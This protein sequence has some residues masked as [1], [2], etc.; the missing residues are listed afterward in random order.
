VAADAVL[1][2]AEAAAGRCGGGGF[3]DGA[4][5]ALQAA[6]RH[7]VRTHQRGGKLAGVVGQVHIDVCGGD[8]SCRVWDPHIY[9]DIKHR[10]LTHW[11][12]TRP[13]E[14]SEAGSRGRS[15]LLGSL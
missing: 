7:S 11:G 9:K 4:D 2:D 14:Q 6:G 15:P 5:G 10:A 1:P 8:D 3:A 12:D 13:V